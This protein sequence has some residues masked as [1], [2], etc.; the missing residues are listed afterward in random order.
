MQYHCAVSKQLINVSSKNYARWPY[1]R[2]K[3]ERPT[4]KRLNNEIPS[5]NTCIQLFIYKKRLHNNLRQNSLYTRKTTDQLEKVPFL[6]VGV[7]MTCINVPGVLAFPI[8]VCEHVELAQPSLP[9][10]KVHGHI[11]AEIDTS[12]M[13]RLPQLHYIY[14]R[15][16]L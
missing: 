16:A 8:L 7:A 11:E 5:I 2:C 10:D 9:G 6:W 3:H 13:H 14:I 4:F 15:H 12:S 1:L